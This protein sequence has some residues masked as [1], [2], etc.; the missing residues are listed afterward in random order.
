MPGGKHF[1]VAVLRCEGSGLE[2]GDYESSNEVT[3]YDYNNGDSNMHKDCRIGVDFLLFCY[4]V[5]H[6]GQYQQSPD[7]GTD[8]R[9]ADW[10]DDYHRYESRRDK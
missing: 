7:D 3:R 5:S 10:Q 8:C 6:N 2:S 4:W 1:E 9:K